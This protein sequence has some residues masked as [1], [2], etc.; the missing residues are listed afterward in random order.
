MR[1]QVLVLISCGSPRRTSEPTETWRARKFEYISEIGRQGL[2]EYS[3]WKDLTS[4]AI[5]V[6]TPR[7]KLGASEGVDPIIFVAASVILPRASPALYP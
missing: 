2:I 4:A 6:R 7:G 1:W 3:D 5:N